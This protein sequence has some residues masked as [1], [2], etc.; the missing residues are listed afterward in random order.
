M[1]LKDLVPQ[2][3]KNFIH[4]L[5]SDWANVKYGFPSDNLKIIGVTGTDGKTTTSTMIY[6]ILKQAGLKV[7][8][9][10]SVSAKI[11]KDEFDTGLHVTTPDPWDIPKYLRMMLEAGIKWVVLEVTSHALDQNRIANITVEKAVFTNITKEHLDYHKTWLAYAQAKAKLIRMVKEGGEVIY[12]RDEIGGKFIEKRIKRSHQV[13]LPVVCDDELVKKKE[14]AREGLKFKYEINREET[15]VEIP[16]LGEYNISNA[17][18]AIKACESLVETSSILEALKEFRGV[19]GRMHVVRRK[20]PCLTIVDFAHTP[21]ALKKALETVNNLKEKGKLIVVFG[22]A[23]LRDRYKRSMMGKIAAKLADIVI[24][25]AEDPRSESL[26]RI[27]SRILEG[28]LSRR[29]IVLKRF[30]NRKAFRKTKVQN[31]KE[32]IQEIFKEGRK[33]VFVFDQEKVYSREDALELAVKLAESEDI[34][35]ATGKGHEKSLCFGSVEYPWSD[36][37]AVRRAVKLRYMK[38]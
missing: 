29:G 15:D 31:L 28:A 10:T 21:N 9:I 33:P 3:I 30:Q 22:C 32:K 1:N 17:Q 37:E 24:I 14:A 35:I 2:F 38:K 27:N 4:R 5:Q 36:F 13:L 8:L 11:G 12:K 19:L 23:G 25:T 34:I 18:C 26:K 16:I 6:S 20:R 7:G